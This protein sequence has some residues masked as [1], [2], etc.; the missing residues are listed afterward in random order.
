[1][2]DTTIIALCGAPGAGKT[3]VA[4]ILSRNHYFKV[5]DDSKA[6]KLLTADYHDIPLSRF[7]CPIQKDVPLE[8]LGGKTPRQ[9]AGDF[10]LFL[11]KEVNPNFSQIMALKQMKP[12]GRYV[13]PSVRMNQPEWWR[14]RFAAVIEVVRPGKSITNKDYDWYSGLA[15]HHTI[16]NNGTLKDLEEKVTG[17]IDRCVADGILKL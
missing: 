17:A 13:V 5:V 14:L 2:K 1:M 3:E 12:G 6:I 7:I 15:V 4:E 16:W 9:A 8:R 11:E 10:G